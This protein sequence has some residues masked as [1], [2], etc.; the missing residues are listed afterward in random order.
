MKKTTIALA[1][2]CTLVLMAGCSKKT[3]E[4]PVSLSD[5][6]SVAAA[7]KAVETAKVS[8]APKAN[9]A[10][11]LDQYQILSSGKQLLFTY[12]ALSAMPA[13]YEKIAA[14][15]SPD[16]RQQTDDF[17]KRDILNALKPAIDKEIEKAKETRYF[18][19]DMSGTVDQF[20]FDQ[21]FFVLKSIGEAS[22]FHYMTDVSEYHYKFINGDKFNKLVV[23]DEAQ[24]RTIEGLR[25]KYDNM[26]LRVYFFIADTELGDKNVLAEITKVVLTDSK[27][28]TLGEVQ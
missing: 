5:A 18:Y 27:G 13:D 14:S 1:C 10:T 28:A 9:K 4:A 20:N 12:Q 24:A 17:K 16:Y 3:D 26:K 11:P 6:H 23:T 19:S 2:A 7:K 15:I 22:S 25:A 8:E 21:K